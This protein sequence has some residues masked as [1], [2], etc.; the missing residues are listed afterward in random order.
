VLGNGVAAAP[1]TSTLFPIRAGVPPC[2]G[3][4]CAGAQTCDADTGFCA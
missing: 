3:V 2:A 4:A 1:Y